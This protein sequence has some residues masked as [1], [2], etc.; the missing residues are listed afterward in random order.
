MSRYRLHRMNL[1]NPELTDRARAPIGLPWEEWFPL[2]KK[3]G[4]GSTLESRWSYWDL[5]NR[6]AAPQPDTGAR[7][8]W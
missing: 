6:Q 5:N 7:M 2:M 3:Q 8:P 1:A 4:L